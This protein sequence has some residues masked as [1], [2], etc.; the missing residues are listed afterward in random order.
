MSSNTKNIKKETEDDLDK[1]QI[2]QLHKAVLGFSSQSFEIKKFCVTIEIS[3]CTLVSTIF[4]NNF[5]EKDDIFI[6]IIKLISFF[7]PALF[8]LLDISTYYYQDKLRKKIFEIENNIRERHNISRKNNKR[9]E[10]KSS[11]DRIFR[12]CRSIFNASNIIYLVL[13]IVALLIYYYI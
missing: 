6:L 1:I 13:I 11:G 10:R 9:F 8:C 4:K 3:A 12:L 2:D 7:I 5:I